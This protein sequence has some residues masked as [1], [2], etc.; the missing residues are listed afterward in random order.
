MNL[1]RKITMDETYINAN[2]ILY[3]FRTDKNAKLRHGAKLRAE[4]VALLQQ[5]KEPSGYRVDWIVETVNELIAWLGTRAVEFGQRYP[6]DAVSADDLSDVL[7]TAQSRI[8][9]AR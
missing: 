7:A 6:Q 1:Q 2:Q 8:K 3:R 4:M 9:R 5:G